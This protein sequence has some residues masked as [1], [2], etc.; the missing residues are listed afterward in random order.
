M[1]RRFFLMGLIAAPLRPA[2]PQNPALDSMLKALNRYPRND[3][4]H[5]GAVADGMTDCSAAF[6]RALAYTRST[7]IP[8]RIAGGPYRLSEPLVLTLGR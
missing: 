4:R 7:G 1:N 3:I 8:A 5:Y 6:N 2:T